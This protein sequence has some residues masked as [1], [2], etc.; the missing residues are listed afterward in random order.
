MTEQD[1]K[2]ALKQAEVRI[3][4]LERQLTEEKDYCKI[5]QERLNYFIRHIPLS[6]AMFDHEM[7]YL[8]VSDKYMQDYKPV[9]VDLIGKNHYEIFPDTP[10]R[11]KEAHQRCLKGV[12]E[13]CEADPYHT[14]SGLLLYIDWVVQPWYI[15]EHEVG[16]LILIAEVANERV[17]A[18]NRL[19]HLNQEL[20]FSN[21]KLDAFASAVLHVLHNPLQAS[22]KLSGHLAAYLK[23]N[24]EA[25]YDMQAEYVQANLKRMERT[26]QGLLSYARVGEQVG[27]YVL[28]LQEIIANVLENLQQS[29]AQNDVR[30]QFGPLP[31]VKANEF[32]MTALFQNLIANAIKHHSGPIRIEIGVQKQ[33]SHWQ[34]HVRDN[35]PGIAHEDQKTLFQPLRNLDLAP[36]YEGVGIGLPVCKR[37]IEQ[38]SGKIWVESSPEEGTTFYFTIPYS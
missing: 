32:E 4:D 17:E 29:I 3:A 12:S 8:M 1:L 27:Y 10:E 28:S 38:M 26:I 15:R 30:I 22:L 18:Q 37:I 16:G 14:R 23:D 13:S 5:L 35:G 2:Q 20:R 6:I 25:D 33:P 7:N 24:G 21:Q 19:K 11:W 9:V 36:G 31:I 34:F